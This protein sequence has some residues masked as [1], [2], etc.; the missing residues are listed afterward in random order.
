MSDA[1]SP[2][3]YDAG[4]PGSRPMPGLIKGLAITAIVL[5]VIGLGQALLGGVGALVAPF[6]TDSVTAGLPS[7][8]AA[9]YEDLMAAQMMLLPVTVL[10]LLFLVS[11]AIAMLAGGI[12]AVQGK[13]VRILGFG[14]LGAAA[15]D[16]IAGLWQIA[17]Q[18]ILAGP[19]QAYTEALG[20]ANPAAAQGAA[21]GGII[22]AVIGAL[23]LWGFAAF[24]V[25]A[26]TRIRAFSA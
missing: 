6:M 10:L 19:M 4:T 2:P 5:G 14:A 9:A 8:A 11:A 1:F 23:F 15:Y 24:W 25:W 21:V 17:T 18:V 13:G 26:W 7:R 3:A 16:G 12:M 22:G 20:A